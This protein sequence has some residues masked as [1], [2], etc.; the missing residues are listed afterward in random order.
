MGSKADRSA[1]DNYSFN[2]PLQ[3]FNLVF[4]LIFAI[5]ETEVE[6]KQ[7]YQHRPKKRRDDE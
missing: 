2:K 1:I 7:E 6:D 4:D 3:T 5:S